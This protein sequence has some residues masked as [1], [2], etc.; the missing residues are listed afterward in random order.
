[1]FDNDR[2]HIKTQPAIND[3][4][5]SDSNIQ[6][7]YVKEFRKHTV[8]Q[9]NTGWCMSVKRK[10]KICPTWDRSNSPNTKEYTIILDDNEPQTISNYETKRGCSETC[11]KMVQPKNKD[12]QTHTNH[13]IQLSWEKLLKI[14]LSSLIQKH[15][16]TALK[17][18]AALEKNELT[19]RTN[20]CHQPKPEQRIQMLSDKYME[21]RNQNPNTS[22]TCTH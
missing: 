14:K 17:N 5:S 16:I 11:T 19:T 15:K 1:M 9:S 20:T 3:F 12:T 4:I 13:G 8:V 18:C 22:H 7:L 6:A 10:L 21:C 2:N